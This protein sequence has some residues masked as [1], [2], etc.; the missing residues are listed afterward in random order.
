ME[1]SGVPPDP[2][3]AH[4]VLGSLSPAIIKS[5]WRY[6]L[7]AGRTAQGGVKKEPAALGTAALLAK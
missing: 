1:F 7:F 4:A 3:W 5:Q 2:R 6:G